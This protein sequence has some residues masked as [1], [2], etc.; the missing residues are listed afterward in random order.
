MNHKLLALLTCLRVFAFSTD[1][2]GGDRPNF[3]GV[4]CNNLGYGD[5]EPFGSTLH[6]SLPA[7]SAV[8]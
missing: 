6:R 7:E 1:V 2:A 5:I 4:F 8:N 3:I